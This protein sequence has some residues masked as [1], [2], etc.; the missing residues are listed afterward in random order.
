MV[1]QG[2]LIAKVVPFGRRCQID[3]AAHGGH[4]LADDIEA[5]THSVLTGSGLF[6]PMKSLEQQVPALRRD[7]FT[8]VMNLDQNTAGNPSGC[9]GHSGSVDAT[10]AFRLRPRRPDR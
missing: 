2:T 5:E 1:G 7:T 8:V 9:N 10:G 4:E 6:D 3:P